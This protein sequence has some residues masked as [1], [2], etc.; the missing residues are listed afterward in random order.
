MRTE[1]ILKTLNSNNVATFSFDISCYNMLRLHNFRFKAID[2]SN[3][4]IKLKKKMW[5]LPEAC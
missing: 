4:I 5:W 1:I 3:C 2:M